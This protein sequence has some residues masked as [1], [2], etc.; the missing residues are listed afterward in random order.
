MRTA[1]GL[2]LTLLVACAGNG[3]SSQSVA[4]GNQLSDAGVDPQPDASDTAS[5]IIEVTRGE[6]RF[7]VRTA[8]P[9]EGEPVILLHGFPQTSL[10]WTAQIAF[11]AQHGYRVIAPDQRGYSPGARPTA[12]A[13]Y[14]MLLLV[15]DVLAI[16]DALG[17]ERFHLVGHDWGASVTWV[18]A[19]FAPQRLLSITPISVPHLDAFTRT[20]SDPTSCQPAASAYIDTF[21][22]EGSEAMLLRDDAAALRTMFRGLP[23]ER[24][25]QYLDHFHD[26][27]SLSGPLNWYRANLAP[28]VPRPSI[29]KTSVPTLY[30]WSE[31]D[32][33]LCRDGAELTGEY[34]DAPYRFEILEGVNHWVP[35][36]A[37]DQVNTLLLAHLRQFAGGAMDP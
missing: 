25:Q 27:S 18:T 21:V 14:A 20:V 29:G 6:L 23:A 33:A 5:Q 37:A 12:L 1:H 7:Q 10:E 31:R 11:L 8:G 13:D 2:F 30:I 4:A 15:Q 3:Q 24:T 35:E 32:E 28:G 36:L 22:E 19:F 16:A 17:V 9:A 34:V 26:E